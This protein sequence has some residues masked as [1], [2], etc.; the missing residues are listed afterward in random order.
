MS[1]STKYFPKKI[2]NDAINELLV[3]IGLPKATNIIV[4]KVD[5]NYHAIYMITLPPSKK[6]ADR[7]YSN[8]L[9]LRVAVD[10]WPRIKTENESGV[11][12]WISQHTEIPIPKLISYE[13]SDQNPLGYEY[14]LLPR[15]PGKPLYDILQQLDD[16][17]MDEILDQLADFLV[18]L[19]S[20][21]WNK[22]GGINI[23]G[24]GNFHVS[25]V[26]DENFWTAHQTSSWPAGETI[27]TLN[28]GGPF[29]TY[30]DYITAQIKL[31]IRLIRLHDR[32]E[33][34]RPQ[35]DSLK[36][37][38]GALNRHAEELNKTRFIL[39]HKDLHFGNIMYDQASGKITAILDW[40]FSGVV[41][42]PKWNPRKAFLWNC[43]RTE[44]SKAEKERLVQRFAQRCEERG[45][46]P[47]PDE[48]EYTSPRQKAM[49]EIADHVRA[50]I[51]VSVAEQ[52]SETTH[53]KLQIDEQVEEWGNTVT[54]AL[55]VFGI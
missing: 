41:P 26:M 30:V 16:K 7:V 37:F 21:R 12:K 10:C 32:L 5:A 46:K 18:E 47:L 43:D 51:E 45:V 9:V 44:K 33:Y 13:S 39:A 48:V 34:Y 29:R 1:T 55:A 35:A 25:R 8:G 23:D 4:P 42:A 17:Q 15:I 53:L 2:S 27:H 49:Q 40:E 24:E 19:H 38:L 50:I 6:A 11:M 31:Y 52:Y 28:I 36:L 22:I 20:H 54:K 14:T 3:N